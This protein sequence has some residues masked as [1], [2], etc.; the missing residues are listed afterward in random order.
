MD[1]ILG[2]HNCYGCGVCAK[3]CGKNLIA[4]RLNE[5][6]FYEPFIEDVDRC[7]TCGL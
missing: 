4:L 7:D 1:N 2:V 6:G 3:V 5:D